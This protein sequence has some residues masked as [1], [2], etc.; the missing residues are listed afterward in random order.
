MLLSAVRSGNILYIF[1]SILASLFLVFCVIPLHEYAHAFAAYKMGDNTAKLQGRLKLN[2]LL[3]ID[4]LGALMIVLT[5]FGWGRPCPIDSRNF[6][7]H[8]KGM[9]LTAI[10]G[11]L[12]NLLL[13]WL[14][15]FISVVFS[16]VSAL[17]N[18][19]IGYA[20]YNFFHISAEISIYLAVLNLLPIPPLDGFRVLSVFLSDKAY[21]TVMA[22]QQIISIIVIVLLFSG[23]LTM[24]LSL[25]AGLFIDFFTALSALPFV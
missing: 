12:S 21:Y 17:A 22:N 11:P 2:P 25:L 15:I 24:P 6:K 3:H 10:A 20:L 14:L 9:I 5:G 23:I 7:D 16:N 13:G 8:R 18:T 1:I 4:P 19:V